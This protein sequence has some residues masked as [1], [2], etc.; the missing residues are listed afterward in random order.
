MCVYKYI[1]YRQH[2]NIDRYFT[3]PKYLGS[4]SKWNVKHPPRHP[5]YKLSDCVVNSGGRVPLGDGHQCMKQGL[6]KFRFCKD[7][8]EM[9][10]HTLRYHVLT[11]W[12]CS[13]REQSGWGYIQSYGGLVH[14]RYSHKYVISGL[15]T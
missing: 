3:Y 2:E 10:D 11:S 14:H 6:E 12:K 9:D 13:S 1:I 8:F 7:S 5:F 15:H 4:T